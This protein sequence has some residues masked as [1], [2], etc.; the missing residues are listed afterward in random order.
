MAGSPERGM[1][2]TLISHYR[3]ADRAPLR[4]TLTRNTYQRMS[5]S[6]QCRATY[7]SLFRGV[8]LII[9]VVKLQL[10]P[11]RKM[12]SGW[13]PGVFFLSDFD[14]ETEAYMQDLNYSIK[15]VCSRNRDGSHTTRS[16]RER[17][18]GQCAT[19]VRAL[20]FRDAKTVHDLKPKHVHRLVD[21]WQRG[22]IATGTIKNRMSAL[23]WLAEKIG[24]ASLVKSRNENYGIENRVYVTNQDKSVDFD[25]RRI[26]AITDPCV[27]ASAMLQ[28]EFGLR[29]EEAMK[30][31]PVYADQGN[32]L[33]LKASWCKGSRER[34]IPIRHESQREAL[35]HAH[36]VAG[37]GS[38]IPRNK[39]YVQHM[40]T[41]ERQ[42][43]K[44]GLART[45]GARHRYAQDRYREMTGRACPARGGKVSAEL[46]R[47]EKAQDREVR[48]QISRE[49]GHERE[50][51]T[52]SYIGR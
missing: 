16:N 45:H 51:I 39:S 22:G 40:R 7:V 34:E 26:D 36:K 30:F 49:L 35:A 6:G 32:H 25:Q 5:F 50:S 15:K 18:L 37:T 27:R 44:V 23:R 14:G 10:D 28:R 13:Q 2:D 46:D 8:L 17:M 20:G 1:L 31:Q 12:M 47:V 3:L 21:S 29:R 4:C 33:V 43:G 24:Q 9:F 52:A 42:M 41:F 11:A 38:L 48:L 19:Q